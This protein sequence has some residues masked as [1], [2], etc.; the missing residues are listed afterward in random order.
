MQGSQKANTQKMA[1]KIVADMNTARVNLVLTTMP[2]SFQPGDAC[3]MDVG[4]I[5]SAAIGSMQ[6]H[7][8]RGFTSKM[9]T[10][11][12]DRMDYG[13]QLHTVTLL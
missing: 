8:R 6:E 3:I 10:S 4:S 9:C 7:I 1:R 2:A 11:L 13:M 12:W 5:L